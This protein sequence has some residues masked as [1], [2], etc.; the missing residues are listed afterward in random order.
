MS[1]QGWPVLFIELYCYLLEII[2]IPLKTDFFSLVS[3]HS[4]TIYEH[5]LQKRLKI[6]QYIVRVL[7]PDL[8]EHNEKGSWLVLP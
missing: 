4:S 3:L 7:S 1:M 2:N 8:L 6:D 5:T